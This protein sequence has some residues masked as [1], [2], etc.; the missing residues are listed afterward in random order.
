[1][2][3]NIDEFV[4][5]RIYQCKIGYGSWN[6]DVYYFKFKNI[7]NGDLDYYWEIVLGSIFKYKKP[8][9]SLYSFLNYKNLNGITRTFEEVE[10]EDIQ[11]LLPMELIVENRKKKIDMLLNEK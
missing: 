4:N 11:H 6:P 10:F 7:V 3:N 8:K 1:M 9:S 5:G 2:I